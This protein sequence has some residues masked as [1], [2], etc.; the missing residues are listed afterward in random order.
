MNTEEYIKKTKKEIDRIESKLKNKS[1][2]LK[3]EK[4]KVNLKRRLLKTLVIIKLWCPALIGCT[5]GVT[6][7]YF[8]GITPFYKD[9]RKEALRTKKEID[10]FNNL[11]YECQYEDYE[12]SNKI[13]V[14]GTWKELDNGLYERIVETYN[15]GTLDED[16]IIEII[17]GENQIES[18]GELFKE[19]PIIKREGK[20]K[21]NEDDMYDTPY[22]QA[23][24]YS[25]DKNDI[26]IVKESWVDNFAESVFVTALIL[27]IGAGLVFLR[28][29]IKKEEVFEAMQREF[30]DLNEKYTFDEETAE[31]LK[32]I[33]EIKKDNYNTLVR[34]L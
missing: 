30:D 26:I 19:D 15:I 22:L 33:L 18:I 27:I 3:K 2:V 4:I 16:K 12:K 13:S 31:H 10:S 8:L 14:I 21:L 6:G 17:E 32:N 1:L 11:H 7:S 24:I 23:T 9:D 34:K 5:L 29:A 20:S 28:D 25:E